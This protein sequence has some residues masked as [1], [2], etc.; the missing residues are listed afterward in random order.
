MLGD[1]KLEIYCN[2]HKMDVINKEEG[3]E[4]RR[5]GGKF[6]LKVLQNERS[7]VLLFK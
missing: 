1:N 3:D 4:G 6:V 5:E 7:K 2:C